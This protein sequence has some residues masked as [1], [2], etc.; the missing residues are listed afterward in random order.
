MK[1]SFVRNHHFCDNYFF[2]RQK[3]IFY[4]ESAEHQFVPPLVL[5]YIRN[6]QSGTKDHHTLVNSL[7]YSLCWHWP[8]TRWEAWAGSG[9]QGIPLSRLASLVPLLSVG[10]CSLEQQTIKQRKNKQTNKQTSIQTDRQT[11][12]QTSITIM[13]K[14]SGTSGARIVR[15]SCGIACLQ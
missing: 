15:L 3:Y 12:K 1:P 7:V 2:C 10:W 5:K 4:V 6:R 8:F 14:E 13:I 9:M 11:D